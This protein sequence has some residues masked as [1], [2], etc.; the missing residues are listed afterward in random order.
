M[1]RHGLTQT[2][3][4][5]DL[6][7]V[8]KKLDAQEYT[9]RSAFVADMTRIFD[10]CRMFNEKGSE[11]AKVLSARES[12]DKPGTIFM[13]LFDIFPVTV[14]GQRRE[15]AAGAAA[16]TRR[17]LAHTHTAPWQLQKHHRWYDM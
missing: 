7:T 14:R 16:R 12:P 17:P 13:P 4:L 1:G 11:F 5:V 8:K 10:N 2:W 3:F 6:S 9:C 15:G